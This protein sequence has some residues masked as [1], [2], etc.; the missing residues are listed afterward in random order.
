MANLDEG[1][2]GIQVL[3]GL[4]DGNGLPSIAEATL[5]DPK[6]VFCLVE[7]RPRKEVHNV[8]TDSHTV[9]LR[10]AQIEPLQGDEAKALREQLDLVRERRTGQRPLISSDGTVPEGTTSGD[11]PAVP[12]DV[13]LDSAAETVGDAATVPAFEPP[14]PIRP[15]KTAAAKPPAKQ[16]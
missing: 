10:I 13:E 2:V 4:P 1:T 9:I 15:G 3:A 16:A 11:A 7:L 14:T 6:P 12:V 8:D 5:D